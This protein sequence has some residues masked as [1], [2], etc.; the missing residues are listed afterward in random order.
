MGKVVA[1]I[2]PKNKISFKRRINIMKLHEEFKE[3]ENLWEASENLKEAVDPVDEVLK[4]TPDYE[5]E[6]EGFD[7]DWYQDKWNPN[8]LYGH[9]Q[10]YGTY[11]YNDFTYTVDAESLFE[12]LIDMLQTKAQEPITSDFMAEYKKLMDAWYKAEGEEEDRACQAMELYVAK[13]LHELADLYYKDIEKYYS[14]DA[15]EWAGENLDPA[16]PDYP[17]PDYDWD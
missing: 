8:S 17:E 11:H 7:E 10:D 14:E 5:L 3:Y 1:I 2:R 15:Y 9:D 16:E 4:Q 6:Y 12:Y 13:N